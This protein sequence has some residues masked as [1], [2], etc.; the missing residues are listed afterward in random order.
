MQCRLEK[1]VLEYDFGSTWAAN[2]THQF[3]TFCLLLFM[4]NLFWGSAL[5]RQSQSVIR[6]AST[7]ELTQVLFPVEFPLAN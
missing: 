3:W 4:I 1:G 5:P 7:G 2:M 6:S